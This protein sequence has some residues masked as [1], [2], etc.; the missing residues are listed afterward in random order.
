[1]MCGFECMLLFFCASLNIYQTIPVIIALT[2][3][4]FIIIFYFAKTTKKVLTENSIRLNIGIVGLFGSVMCNL[5]IAFFKETATLKIITTFVILTVV[6]L[7][8]SALFALLINKL[9]KKKK[10]KNIDATP[11]AFSGALF[12]IALNRYC[13]SKGIQLPID[14]IIYVLNLIF[15]FMTFI[16][17]LTL[18]QSEK[19]SDTDN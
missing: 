17:L 8:I 10:N 7:I 19:K 13:E 1:M 16:H 4:A 9:S 15:T 2:S 6:D 3:A 18:I 11:F 14:I 5:L 12:G